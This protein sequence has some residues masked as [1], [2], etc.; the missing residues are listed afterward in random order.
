MKQMLMTTDEMM[1]YI[2][3]WKNRFNLP[4]CMELEASNFEVSPSIIVF[5]QFT[6][7][8]SLSVTVT[9]RNVSAVILSSYNE[10][11]D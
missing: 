5:Q 2:L 3:K 4:L 9:V 11:L 6:P 8:I 1:Q 10:K 7:G